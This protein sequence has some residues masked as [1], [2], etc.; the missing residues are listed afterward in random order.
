M[1]ADEARHVY[2]TPSLV[3]LTGRRTF[4]CQLCGRSISN[5]PA[6]RR[7][8]LV[9]GD[10]GARAL[11][12]MDA[13]A[14]AAAA[15]TAAAAAEGQPAPE[16]RYYCPAPDCPHHPG[17]DGG[18]AGAYPFKTLRIARV[19]YMQEHSDAPEEGLACGRCGRRYTLRLRLRTHE[20]RCGERHRCSCAA[21]FTERRS[22]RNHLRLYSH[23]ADAGSVDAMGRDL[24]QPGEEEEEEN[25]EEEGMDADEAAEQ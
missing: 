13:D 20:R 18:G 16:P 5:A 21:W 19:H 10:A 7:H 25:E 14:A 23:H 6:L 22:L 12:A 2:F 1:R 8:M 17:P 3:E 15:A 4:P 24:P 11:A 9:H